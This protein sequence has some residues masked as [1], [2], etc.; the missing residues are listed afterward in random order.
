MGINCN[1]AL[2]KVLA[3]ESLRDVVADIELESDEY[4]LPFGITFD[5][6]ADGED[7]TDEEFS[8]ILTGLGYEEDMTDEEYEDLL[9]ELEMTDEEYEEA[10]KAALE[11][12]QVVRSASGKKHK[13]KK[14]SPAQIAAGK[15]RR[16]KKIKMSASDKKKRAAKAAKTRKRRGT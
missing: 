13:V 5:E 8:E 7:I 15:K 11:A 16:G 2:K 6:D 1:E 14:G 10:M 4:K 3:G 12:G 9:E